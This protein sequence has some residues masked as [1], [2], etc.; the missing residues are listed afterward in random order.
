MRLSELFE[1]RVKNAALDAAFKRTPA[2]V[3]VQKFGILINGKLWKK[4]G[5]TV[6]F[7]NESTA[8]KSANSITLRRDITTQV[9]PLM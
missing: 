7:N 4:D 1:G 2:P 8:K 9:V 3:E 5:K 6:I